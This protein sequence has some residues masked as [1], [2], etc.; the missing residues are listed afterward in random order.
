MMHS[1]VRPS[2]RQ[3]REPLAHHVN[4]QVVEINVAAKPQHFLNWQLYVEVV[5]VR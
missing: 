3:L 2:E 1:K 4:R 5:E